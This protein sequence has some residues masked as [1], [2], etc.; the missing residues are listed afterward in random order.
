MDEFLSEAGP[1][2]DDEAYLFIDGNL[3]YSYSF[4]T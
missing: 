2:Y 1:H 3:A 4:H